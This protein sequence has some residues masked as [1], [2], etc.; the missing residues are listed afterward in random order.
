[1]DDYLIAPI[2]AA[3]GSRP[4][5]RPAAAMALTRK[6]AWDGPMAGG[7]PPSSFAFVHVD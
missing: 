3:R 5:A 2:R 6:L 1:V 4:A 7:A